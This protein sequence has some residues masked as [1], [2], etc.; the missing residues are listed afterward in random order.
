[1]T[2]TTLQQWQKKDTRLDVR[3]SNVSGC[4]EVDSDELSLERK[5]H[6]LR[7]LTN[8]KPI[9]KAGKKRESR[10]LRP[11]L[12][13]TSRPDNRTWRHE[14]QRRMTSHLLGSV[15]AANGGRSKTTIARGKRQTFHLAE[16]P[17]IMLIGT[18]IADKA[19]GRPT[20]G[21]RFDT[22]ANQHRDTSIFCGR[23]SA[24]RRSSRMLVWT[25]SETCHVA[26][27]YAL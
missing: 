1:M 3:A 12:Y 4:V 23:G 18:V 16:I 14:G 6:V 20:H 7:H 27:Q 21:D 9:L 11:E 26:A 13:F 5:G 2:A 8:C 10:F 19:R 22:W 25:R 17:R 24:S 15:V